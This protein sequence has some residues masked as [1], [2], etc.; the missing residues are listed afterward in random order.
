[1]SASSALQGGPAAGRIGPNAI[2]RVA[3]VLPERVGTAATLALF[4]A[5]GLVHHLRQPPQA[6]VDES[7]VWSLHDALRRQLGWPLA[8]EVAREAGTRTGSYLLAHRIPRLVQRLLKVL[9][10]RVAARVLCSA[11]TRHAWTFAGSGSFATA[12]AV[13]PGVPVRLRIRDN[14]MCRD[15]QAETPMCDFYAAVFERLFREL[16]HPRARVTETACEACGAEACTFD[17]RWDRPC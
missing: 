9:P 12:F 3:E 5:A 16:V 6:M 15:V 2:T 11:I 10:A 7:D 8:R 17:I 14:P 13:E 1:M 4:E